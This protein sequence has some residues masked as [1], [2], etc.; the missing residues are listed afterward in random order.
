MSY[1][2][3]RILCAAVRAV[4]GH[5]FADTIGDL[6]EHP[7][8]YTMATVSPVLLRNVGEL[9]IADDL[10]SIGITRDTE[11]ITLDRDNGDHEVYKVGD[12]VKVGQAF[13]AL[14]AAHLEAFPEHPDDC[15]TIEEDHRFLCRVCGRIDG[16]SDFC[17]EKG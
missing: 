8:G 13:D 4:Y 2:R 17:S 11:V 16:H 3:D 6:S 5:G 15:P 12:A 9:T 7:Y 1:N 14:E 10:E